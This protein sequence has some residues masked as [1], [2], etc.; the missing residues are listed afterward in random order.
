MLGIDTLAR[1]VHHDRW[2]PRDRLDIMDMVMGMEMGMG[3]EMAMHVMDAWNGQ[4]HE[5]HEAE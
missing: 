2:Y 3:M 4:V 1:S 5:W